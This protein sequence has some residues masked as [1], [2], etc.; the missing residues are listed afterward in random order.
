MRKRIISIIVIFVMLTGVSSAVA[1]NDLR[2]TYFKSSTSGI[3]M[4]DGEI[5]W[6]GDA[7]TY[8]F[9]EVTN[10]K[11]TVK[12][13]IATPGGWGTLETKTASGKNDAGAVGTRPNW[14]PN[15]SYRVSVEAWAYNGTKEIESIGP[16][17]E[18]LN[19]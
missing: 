5:E 16:F 8:S 1:S 18:Y 7:T 12:L 17:Y 10:T 15:N 11:V 3:L 13:Q 9:Q 6:S 4:V 14:A 19:T 2:W